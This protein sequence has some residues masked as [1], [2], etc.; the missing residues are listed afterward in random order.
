M[1][2]DLSEKGVLPILFVFLARTKNQ[3]LDMQYIGLRKDA[4]VQVLDKD[5]KEKLI[6]G[7]KIDFVPEG[8]YQPRTLYYFSGDLSDSGLKKAPEFKKFVQSLGKSITYLKAASYLLH[9]DS[10]SNMRNLILSQ[11]TALLQDDSG[12]PVRYFDN[13]KW[14]L[15]FYG[16]YTQPI[17]LFS[18]EYQGALKS[19]YQSKT[20]VKPLDFGIGYRYQ[21][22]DSNLML[23]IHK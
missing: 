19:I 21:V 17:S 8:E 6:P 22:N 23:G 20:N 15:H 16:N 4:T 11:S 3:I 9:Y 5:N 12:I 10:F 7:V 2:V 18:N 13:S 14:K 1:K